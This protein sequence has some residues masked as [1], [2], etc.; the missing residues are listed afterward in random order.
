M[1]APLPVWI[2]TDPGVDDFLATLLALRS[3]ELVV[4]ALTAVGGNCALRHATANALRL[5]EY[6]NSSGIPVYSGAS[7]PLR[8][9]FRYAPYFHGPSG[10][11]GRMRKP[12]RRS[13]Q[14]PAVEA[15]ATRLCDLH[16]SAPA[17]VALGP[18]TNIA[19]LI[20]RFPD[21]A[22]RI[23]LLVVMGGALDCPGNV[24][25]S[26]EFN[27]WNDPEAAS[28]VLSSG[29]PT[30]LIGL[31]VCSQVR[32]TPPDIEEAE[33][34][35]RRMM[36]GWFARRP[37]GDEFSMCDPLAVASAIRPEML[38]FE[39]TPV[40]V[41]ADGHERGRTLRAREGPLVDVAVG[42]D[43]RVAAALFRERILT[44]RPA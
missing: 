14:S 2:D 43:S 15:L 13:E 26:A 17:V 9:S 37:N 44:G 19:L 20:R 35:V 39:S 7:R 21:A 41:V 32:L 6:T 4:E 24:S 42:V 38:T 22:R 3:P 29:V 10:L 1:N 16:R 40:T 23:P 31:D 5:L 11:T 18:L 33:P 34:V 27:I 25:P 28:I 12:L 36:A 30:R 8:R